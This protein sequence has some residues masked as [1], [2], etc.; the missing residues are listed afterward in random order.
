MG[1]ELCLFG[2]GGWEFFFVGTGGVGVRIPSSFFFMNEYYFINRG[3]EDRGLILWVEKAESFNSG[4]GVD[5]AWATEASGRYSG[6][7]LFAEVL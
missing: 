5:F 1:E 7:Q 6:Q 4:L 3:D 2:W